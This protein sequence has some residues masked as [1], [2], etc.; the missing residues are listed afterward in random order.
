[1][2]WILKHKLMA[3]LIAIAISAGAW[4]FLSGSSPSPVLSD[5]NT[6]AVPAGAQDLVSSLL[7]LRSVSLNESIFSDPSF[8]A[9]QDFTT[10]VQAEPIGRDDPFSSLT[11]PTQ[12][13]AGAT[14]A[15]QIF[16]KKH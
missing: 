10:P 5:T 8:Q 16:T 1:M 9:L 2:D 11:V 4:Y 15:A 12:P 14:G 3:I 7:A 6:N 13:A